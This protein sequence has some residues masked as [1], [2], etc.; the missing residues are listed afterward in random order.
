MRRQTVIE[1]PAAESGVGLP[2]PPPPAVAGLGA[3]PA[4]SNWATASDPQ[5]NLYYYNIITR[6]PPIVLEFV[7]PFVDSGNRVGTRQTRRKAVRVWVR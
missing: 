5:G 1:E 4:A 6:F 3:L 2:P 7:I